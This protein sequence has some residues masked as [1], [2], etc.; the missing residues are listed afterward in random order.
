MD[1]TRKGVRD[2]ARLRLN[3]EGT[4]SGEWTD[5]E[6]NG[7]LDEWVDNMSE[8]AAY[9]QTASFA[10]AADTETVSWDDLSITQI[11]TLRD[12]RWDDATTR[13]LLLPHRGAWSPT[14]EKGAPHAYY[15]FAKTFYLRPIPGVAGTLLVAYEGALP[16]FTS[17][18]DDTPTSTIGERWRDLPMYFCTWKARERSGHPEAEQESANYARRATEFFT[19]RKAALQ[20][21]EFIDTGFFSNFRPIGLEDDSDDF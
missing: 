16:Y 14:R 15:E 3:E 12:V 21:T 20:R 2:R 4:T 13:R 11:V 18:S 5:D 1:I 6:L 19:K 7:Y 9:E 10:V 17:D 8:N